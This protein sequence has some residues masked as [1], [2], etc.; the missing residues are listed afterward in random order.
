MTKVRESSGIANKGKAESGL[1]HTETKLDAIA[2]WN[3]YHEEY[4]VH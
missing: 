2:E 3:Q 1:G 4:L